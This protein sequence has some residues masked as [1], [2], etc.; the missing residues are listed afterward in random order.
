MSKKLGGHHKAFL[1]L[2]KK[3]KTSIL[4]LKLG[5]VDTIVVSGVENV[6]AVL[7][8]EVYDGRPWNYFIKLRNMGKK[9]G[10]FIFLVI[11]KKNNMQNH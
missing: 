3:Y 11:Y 2:S 4:G 1:E 7:T 5:G 9:K 6:N 10:D 8:S